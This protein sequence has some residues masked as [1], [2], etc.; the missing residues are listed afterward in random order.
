MR[1]PAHSKLV[2]AVHILNTTSEVVTGH[3]RLA[4]YSL[5]PDQVVTRLAPFHLSY[6]GLDIPA[7]STAR[8]TGECDVSSYFQNVTKSP[9]TAKVYWM[10][11]HT[12]AL[13]S[14]FFVEIL[15]GPNDG[16]SIIDV[17]D[18]FGEANGTRYTPPID[19]TGALGFRFGCEFKNPRS[20][21]V[22]WGFGDQEMCEA[23]GFYEA[24]LA[25][26]SIIDVANPDG[27]DGT[28]LKFT[29]P[30]NTITLPWQNKN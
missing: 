6:D 9:F 14:R 5:E 10:L 19:M 28:T 11:P 30:C 15:G 23:L 21:S 4:L 12:H 22:K 8:F 27:S 7:N 13:G 29:G 3:I 2:S 18:F 20:E 17:Q 16:Q 25:F 24:P 26:E 1:V